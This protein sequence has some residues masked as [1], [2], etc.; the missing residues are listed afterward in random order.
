MNQ[1]DLFDGSIDTRFQKFHA[2]NPKVYELFVR[3]S[4]EA[5]KAGRPRIGAKMLAE[6]IRW[7]TSV[8]TNGGSWKLNNTFVSRYAR[9]I[10]KE[11]PDLAP[12]FETRSLKS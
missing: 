6:R 11:R 3:F 10:A 7:Y 12:L 2:E 9:L 8:E 4:E 1:G 5:I